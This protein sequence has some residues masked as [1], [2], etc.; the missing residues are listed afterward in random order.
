MILQ[1]IPQL[2]NNANKCWNL[3]REL[4]AQ[5]EILEKDFQQNHIDNMGERNE[6]WD[7]YINQLK[8]AK[9]ALNAVAHMNLNDVDYLIEQAEMEK[10]EAE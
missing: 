6:D 1:T 3:M 5:I 9:E 4:D 2:K 8:S 10:E 7:V